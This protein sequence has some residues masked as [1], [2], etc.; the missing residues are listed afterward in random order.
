MVMNM[1][2]IILLITI[3]AI[4][5]SALVS[6]GSPE[7]DSTQNGVADSAVNK[8]FPTYNSSGGSESYTLLTRD[9]I[10]SIRQEKRNEGFEE[11]IPILGEET[12]TELRE[13]YTLYGDE[14]YMWMANLYDPEAGGFY[15][16]NSGRD[17]IGF[18]AD[19]E[20]TVQV[21]NHIQYGGMFVNSGNSYATGL[22]EEIREAIVGFTKGLQSPEDGY[23]YHPQWGKDI[24]AS[25]KGR[26][27]GWA[28][29]LLKAFGEKPIYDAPDGT[30]GELGAPGQAAAFS[31]TERLSASSVTAVSKVVLVNSS[32]SSL[33]DYLKSL[34][35]WEQY[36]NNLDI[37]HNSYSAGNTL[38]AM[39]GQITQAGDEYVD[40]LID[41]LDELQNPELGLWADEITY[42]SVNGLMKLI[43][44]YSYHSRLI[45]NAD[46]AMNSA[47]QIALEPNSDYH[48]CCVYNP[49]VT[50]YLVISL[51]EQHGDAAQAEQ[52]RAQVLEKS[53]QLISTTFGKLKNYKV[54]GGFHY[55]RTLMANT[56]QEAPVACATEFE[57][58][59]NA[60]CISSSGILSYMYGAFGVPSD[61]QVRLYYEEDKNQFFDEL[62]SIQSVVKKDPEPAEA[63]TFDGYDASLGNEDK[64]V[65]NTPA[66]NAEVI[67]P[68]TTLDTSGNYKFYS[69]SVTSSPAPSYSGD[70]AYNMKNFRYGSTEGVDYAS[71]MMSTVFKIDNPYLR[72]NTYILDTDIMVEKSS[73]PVVMQLFIQ[74]TANTMSLNFETVY[75]TD[76]VTQMQKTYVKIS[77][78]F[79]GAD[80]VKN[81]NIA[82]TMELG[83][84]FNLR[85]ELYKIY[86]ISEDGTS[87]KLDLKAKIFIDGKFVGES[88]AF[89][90]LESDSTKY[91]DSAITQA[92]FALYRSSNCS[93]W[94]DNV[95]VE[96]SNKDYYDLPGDMPAPSGSA[97]DGKYFGN[98]SSAGTKY[99]F[100][101]DENPPALS[102]GISGKTW[103][104]KTKNIYGVVENVT[105]CFMRTE[106]GDGTSHEATT[107]TFTS[108]AE[109][110]ENMVIIAEM[111]F[112]M[113]GLASNAGYQYM[114][115]IHGGGYSASAYV[116]TDADGNLYFHGAKNV[117][118]EIPALKQN[119]WYNIR[120]EG[121]VIDSEKMIIKVF[122]NNEYYLEVDGLDFKES[123][124]SKF[125]NQMQ[126]T[127][128]KGAWMLYDNVFAG[129]DS[130]EYF[131]AGEEPEASAPE[132]VAANIAFNG[133]NRIAVAVDASTV[134]ENVKIVI[135]AD[136]VPAQEIGYY[137]K[138]TIN[139]GGTSMECYL[140]ITPYIGQKDIAKVYSFK[141]VDGDRESS[142]AEISVA[143]YYYLRLFRDGIASATEGKALA[144]K[145]LYIANL[146]AGAAA[147]NL[148][149]NFNSDKS[150]DASVLANAYNIV[151]LPDT[152]PV[153]YKNSTTVL[154]LPAFKG[155][156][157]MGMVFANYSVAKYDA[158]YIKTVTAADVG[159]EITIDA[160]T[161]VTAQFKYSFEFGQGAYYTD[162]T[163]DGKRLDF[164]S[165]TSQTN[166]VAGSGAN[167]S[168]ADALSLAQNGTNSY[169]QYIRPSDSDENYYLQFNANT[170]TPAGA[171]MVV[172]QDILFTGAAS[173]AQNIYMFDVFMGSPNQSR[174]QF[175]AH[176]DGNGNIYF[177]NNSELTLKQDIWY[178]VRFE[179][180][181][182]GTV[183]ITASDLGSISFKITPNSSGNSSR[184]NYY[185]KGNA[186]SH[187]MYIDNIYIGQIQ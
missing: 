34:T 120:L 4:T 169:L 9:E 48:V 161:V 67:L 83:K 148:F 96:K 118:P 116:G 166:I 12:V 149:Y 101:D 182:D 73:S 153:L 160:N 110:P 158:N 66:D 41:Y 142:A 186:D 72:G 19:I 164:S 139:F 53:A 134:S 109:R 157:P 127:M 70:L 57:A 154:S 69:T 130:K 151:I 185:I 184:I 80:G 98:I 181:A 8:N 105:V 179:F 58:D 122:V 87:K 14:I 86:S 61:K 107:H 88:E 56:S 38:S 25:R 31:L 93:V 23:F 81:T 168:G 71:S 5:L 77:E 119:T 132:I 97:P 46:K 33:P 165:S 49:W 123:S 82:D 117:N 126:Y 135:E 176:S 155:T 2:K 78:N 59:V 180:Y 129:Y 76:P 18:G 11:L 85:V 3:F 111:D 100:T 6:C 156:A 63:E 162:Q 143:E 187:G 17:H 183:N 174:I 91:A 74:G 99:D 124:S 36:L 133:D 177:H 108:P 21:L 30:K 55:H 92:N 60:T 159:D 128:D 114:A 20:S 89:K 27:L 26:D 115:R 79:A 173:S 140:F 45:P 163:Y 171:V 39:H 146:N 106:G 102:Y 172:E 121:Y 64:G 131:V 29:Q 104:Y 51:T 178:N 136:G 138:E 94:L 50:M 144:Q 10:A 167:N 52:L 13:L 150:D 147:E 103:L 40:F 28:T 65:V 24:V 145:N 90:T 175:N 137:A 1:K 43:S 152:D 95:K 141:A 68:D 84:W 112:A 37:Y 7:A 35:A 15:Y 16:S 113:G 75:K 44:T 170:N 22:P 62:S 42:D 54:D 32:R 47:I 125:I